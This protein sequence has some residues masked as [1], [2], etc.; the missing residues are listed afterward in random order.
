FSMPAHS[1]IRTDLASRVSQAGPR[2][3]Y[4][5]PLTTSDAAAAAYNR[6]VHTILTVRQG[7]VD[8]LA[9]SIA[10]DPTFALGHAALAL[11]A[12]EQGAPVNVSARMESARRH[13]ARSTARERSHVYAVLSHI[14]GDSRPLLEHLRQHPRDA[15]LLTTAVPTI[16]FA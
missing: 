10:H 3:L 13:A 15:L 8:A 4:G 2:D 7:G 6:G 5:L 1:S 9:E 14:A 16:A 12:H 11:L